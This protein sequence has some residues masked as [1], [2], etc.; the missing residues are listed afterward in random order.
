MVQNETMVSWSNSNS[1]RFVAQ[2]EHLRLRQ[3]KG[4]F[5]NAYLFPYSSCINFSILL[6]GIIHVT[7]NRTT[8]TTDMMG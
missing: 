5:S 4:H 3:A 2:R 6:S 1:L 8:R 7:I